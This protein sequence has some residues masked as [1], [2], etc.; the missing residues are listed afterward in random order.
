MR[1]ILTGPKGVGKSTLVRRAMEKLGWASPAGFSTQRLETP[2]REVALIISTWNGRSALIAKWPSPP[3]NPREL[4]NG[5]D[6]H[7][8][9]NFTRE[10]FS[11]PP[12]PDQPLLI[13]ELGLVELQAPE[14]VA[15]VARAFQHSMVL[16]VVQHRALEPWKDIIGPSH[17]DRIL[18][19]HRP[20]NEGTLA[21]IIDAFRADAP[22]RRA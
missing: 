6:R 18:V 5:L 20:P 13:D 3:K 11:A 7:A 16:A 14:F 4:L 12:P 8:L 15:Q 19:L 9:L 21:S 10:H 17:V 1:M 2:S 22:P